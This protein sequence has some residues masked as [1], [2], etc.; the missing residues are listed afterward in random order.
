MLV[1]SHFF[2]TLLSCLF[3]SQC[4]SADSQALCRFIEDV[5]SLCPPSF[6]PPGL[7][8][9]FW[10]KWRRAEWPFL[11]CLLCWTQDYAFFFTTSPSNNAHFHPYSQQSCASCH[12]HVIGGR[13]K[14]AERGDVLRIGGSVFPGARWP[15]T[16]S[17][18]LWVFSLSFERW[19][20]GVGSLTI[21]LETFDTLGKKLEADRADR[22]WH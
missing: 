4:C 10:T 2:L 5:G 14:E 3:P 6:S 7:W 21:Q 12:E 19:W 13:R 9:G 22:Q 20:C 1:K 16:Q 8:Y 18:K 15:F 11:G 17:I